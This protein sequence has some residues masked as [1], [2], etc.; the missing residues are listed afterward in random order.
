MYVEENQYVTKEHKQAPTI[1]IQNGFD[2]P[3][4]L[5]GI[6]R[7]YNVLTF[8]GPGQGSVI[9]EQK[10]PFR[11]D[12]E[13]VVT[14]VIDYLIA[15]S[16]IDKNMIMLYGLSYGGYMAPRAAAFDN[17]IKILGIFDSVIGMLKNFKIMAKTKEDLL[18]FIR[19]HPTI[20]NTYVYI[21][22][23]FKTATRWFFEH[24]FYAFNAQTPS[25]LI[26]KLADWSMQN[27]VQNITSTTLI[28]DVDNEMNGIKGQASILYDQLL[29]PKKLI[30]F[31]TNE[32]AFLRSNQVVFDWIDTK[33]TL[34]TRQKNGN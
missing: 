29:C 10:L 26:L 9:R 5:E 3:H 14:P 1:I 19:K 25:D 11:A 12:W 18:H 17:R 32:G 27:H 8:E 24:G 34:L 21:G 4:A 7:G 2:G 28:C 15:R 20:F 6:K 13:K 23:H 22:M 16:D 31:Q 30:T 33:V